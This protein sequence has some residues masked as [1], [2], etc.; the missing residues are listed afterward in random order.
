M[1]ETGRSQSG[2]YPA[3]CQSGRVPFKASWP[4]CG[5]GGPVA[6]WL[7][8]LTP[9]RWSPSGAPG[10][11]RL[12]KETTSPGGQRAARDAPPLPPPGPPPGEAALAGGE[13]AERGLEVGAVRRGEGE[14]G[15]QQ[16]HNGALGAPVLP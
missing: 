14:L 1:R 9:G 5:W 11:A 2:G 8:A 7:S 12:N 6:G 3:S 15:T 13:A 10:A 16:M 4:E